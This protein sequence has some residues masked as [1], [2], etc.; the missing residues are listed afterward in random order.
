GSPKDV[1]L[2]G[3]LFDVRT[4]RVWLE[5][6][7][8]VPVFYLAAS[9]S[10]SA[11]VRDAHTTTCAG[12]VLINPILD[13][14][15]IFVRGESDWG[16][17]VVSSYRDSAFAEGD[18]VGR[19]PGNDYVVTTRL[20]EEIK[21][22]ATLDRV[23]NTTVPTLIFHGSADTLV[24][25]DPVLVLQGKD[26]IVDVVIYEGG[27]HGLKEFRPDLMDRTERWLLEHA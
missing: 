3:E 12:L 7:I 21:S 24:P 22:D 4:V 9:F 15:G 2:R 13:Y 25:V 10:A 27:R 6:L 16:A 17:K 8:S 23:R 5:T 20:L 26:S 18:I 11:A 14:A 1:T 19:L